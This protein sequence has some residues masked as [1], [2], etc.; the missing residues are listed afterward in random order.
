MLPSN[1]ESEKKDQRKSAIITFVISALFLFFA[2]YIKVWKAES[3]L[4][5]SFGIEMAF[6]EVVES[7]KSAKVEND[8][9]E[10][11]KEVIEEATE[12]EKSEPNPVVESNTK[13]ELVEEIISPEEPVDEVVPEEEIVEDFESEEQTE[14]LEQE[15]IPEINDDIVEQSEVEKKAPTET[16]PVVK[17]EI[18]E[19]QTKNSPQENNEEELKE[20]RTETVTEEPAP[21]ENLEVAEN[22]EPNSSSGTSETAKVEDKEGDK[23]SKKKTLKPV[24]YPNSTNSNGANAASLE[25]SGWMWDGA[26]KPDDKSKETG[27]VVFQIKIDDQGEILSVITLEKSVSSTVEQ[28]YKREVEKLTFSPLGSND[29]PAAMSTGRITFLIKSN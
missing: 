21:S 16:Q 5:P 13:S 29:N 24:L 7:K 10:P 17:E 9:A 25:M 18:S 14:E 1:G 11:V 12:T 19:E 27:K 22:S 3:P 4:M 6:G 15:D 20:E 26:P 23:D 28:I 2:W 8:V